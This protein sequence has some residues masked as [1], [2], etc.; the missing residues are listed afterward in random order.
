[1]KLIILTFL[2]CLSNQLFGQQV[3]GLVVDEITKQPIK[4]AVVTTSNFSTFTT[5]TGIFNIAGINLGDTIKVSHMCYKP[6]RIIYKNKTKS[7]TILVLLKVN[8][9][10]LQEVIVK[11]MR[12][13]KQDSLNRRK[14]FASTFAYEPPKFKDIFLKRSPNAHLQNYPLQNS[15]STLVGVNILSVIGLINKNKTPVS[16]LQKQLLKDEEFK[17]VD[18]IFS[19]EKVRS[20]TS[21]K[22]DS[23]Q[24]FM[25]Q[26]RPSIEKSKQM[27]EYELILHIKKS[28]DKFIKVKKQETLPSLIK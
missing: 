10:E 22:G 15:T 13:Y 8:A 9:I 20:L 24:S 3:T 17:Y 4:D 26:Y 19:T 12:N 1:M 27:T 14:E 5:S 16:K 28:Y 18:H 2:V 7:D 11:G 23:L 6:V 21:L 25:N